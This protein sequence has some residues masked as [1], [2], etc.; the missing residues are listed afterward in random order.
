MFTR[1]RQSV[2]INTRG[3]YGGERKVM[4]YPGDV[5]QGGRE[6]RW[7]GPPAGQRGPE[8][9]AGPAAEGLTWLRRNLGAD[10]GAGLC[11][12]YLL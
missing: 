3:F 11:D 10:S 7:A 9:E 1:R 8:A 4:A 6:A 2:F 5:W 12:L